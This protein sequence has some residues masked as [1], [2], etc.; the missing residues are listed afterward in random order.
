MHLWKILWALDTLQAVKQFL[1]TSCLAA[2]LTRLVT[3]NELFSVGNVRL[4]RFVLAHSTIHAIF[5]QTEVFGVVAW[6]F[7]DTAKGQ[8]NCAG[9]DLIEKV[10]VMS[11]YNHCAFPA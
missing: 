7:L 5:T 9:H 1:T 10:A 4:L 8:F 2:A 11:N 6:I 3:A